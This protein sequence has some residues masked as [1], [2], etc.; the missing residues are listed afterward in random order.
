MNLTSL[1]STHR[2]LFALILSIHEYN[3]FY[4]KVMF[5]KICIIFIYNKTLNVKEIHFLT[6]V[7]SRFQNVWHEIFSMRPGLIEITCF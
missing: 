2:K 1:T 3:K 7:V 4:I 6:Y 5:A